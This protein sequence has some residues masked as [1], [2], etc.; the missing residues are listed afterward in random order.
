MSSSALGY[1][2]GPPS[3]GVVVA[4]SLTL[5]GVVAAIAT[6]PASGGVV[7]LMPGTYVFAG[8]SLTINKPNVHIVG[9]GKGATTI[10]YTGVTNTAIKFNSTEPSALASGANLVIGGSVRSLTIEGPGFNNLSD[11][12]RGVL[13]HHCQGTAIEDVEFIGVAFGVVYKWCE[14]IVLSKLSARVS[15]AK[16]FGTLLIAVGLDSGT[17]WQKNSAFVVDCAAIGHAAQGF[18]FVYASGTALSNCKASTTGTTNPGFLVGSSAADQQGD[19]TSFKAVGCVSEGGSVGFQVFAPANVQL[20][21]GL[22]FDSCASIGAATAGFELNGGRGYTLS[23]CSVRNSG[24]NAYKLIGASAVAFM[25][26]VSIGNN[27]ASGASLA[28]AAFKAVSGT[29][30]QVTMLGCIVRAPFAACH[31]VDL[32]IA[33]LVT[34]IGNSFGASASA[35]AFNATLGAG[36]TP[37]ALHSIVENGPATRQLNAIST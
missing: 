24:V 3:D 25:G 16:T 6:L 19:L 9:A 33:T 8:S 4:D 14:S 22:S 12:H 18:V 35:T 13:V 30:S 20:F 32:V 31:G 26:C 1:F 28:S 27:T 5:A 36:A 15:G 23:G 7:Q 11:N 2:S 21:E 17:A 29:V 34:C 37:N 10:S